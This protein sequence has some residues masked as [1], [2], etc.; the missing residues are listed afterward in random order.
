MACYSHTWVRKVLP[1]WPVCQRL[2]LLVPPGLRLL[3]G[4]LFFARFWN[5]GVR[6]LGRRVLLVILCGSAANSELEG[7]HMLLVIQDAHAEYLTHV[8]RDSYLY[9]ALLCVQ[10]AGC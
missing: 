6:L 7:M 1:G 5:I 3:Q 9:S 2:E 4:G 10:A 8:S